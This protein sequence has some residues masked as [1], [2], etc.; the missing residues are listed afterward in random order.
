MCRLQ[1]EHAVVALNKLACKY[2]GDITMI[3]VGPLTNAACC[4]KMY[5]KFVK[6]VKHF[7][8]MGGNWM[9]KW[10]KYIEENI[11]CIN[12]NRL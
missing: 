11:F 9:G 1:E 5:P 3:F 4:I 12:F 7:Y 8:V 6:M 2:A 10:K